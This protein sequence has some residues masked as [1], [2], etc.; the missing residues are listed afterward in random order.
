MLVLPLV[1]LLIVKELLLFLLS[2]LTL[3]QS[4]GA[5]LS[6]SRAERLALLLLLGRYCC[7]YCSCCFCGMGREGSVREGIYTQAPQI[8][9]MLMQEFGGRHLHIRARRVVLGNPS[10]TGGDWQTKTEGDGGR[11]AATALGDVKKWASQSVSCV[12]DVEFLPKER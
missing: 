11:L 10:I 8:G 3:L 7:Y 12:W 9:F 2:L 4:R 5:M 6:K 1:L